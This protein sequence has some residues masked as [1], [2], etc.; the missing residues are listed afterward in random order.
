MSANLEH[1]RALHDSLEYPVPEMLGFLNREGMAQFLE[2]GFPNS[3]VEGFKYTNLASRLKQR[4]F[5]L[6]PTHSTSGVEQLI[7]SNRLPDHCLIVF[8]SGQLALLHA[9][10]LQKLGCDVVAFSSSSSQAT[11]EDFSKTLEFEKTFQQI[12]NTSMSALNQAFFGVSTVE[13][14]LN[15]NSIGNLQIIY[16]DKPGE[17]P[18]LAV[19][20]VNIAVGADSQV[21]VVETFIQSERACD[22][23]CLPVLNIHVQKAARLKLIKSASLGSPGDSTLC[24]HTKAL[25]EEGAQFDSFNF[26][27]GHG[28][29]RHDL[30]VGLDGA[31]AS[32]NVNGVY[33][34]GKNQHVDNQTTLHHK[35]PD[36]RSSQFYK[37]V[38][39]SN[40]RGVF[41]GLVK[42]D[43]DAQRSNASQLNKNLMLGQESQIDTKPELEIAADDVKCSHG[44]TIGQLSELELFYL[45][46]R[47][48]GADQAKQMLARGFI[49]EVID[50]FVDHPEVKS[51]METMVDAFLAE[52]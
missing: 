4:L 41:S 43:K 31:E 48:I 42:V 10:E 18:T 13:L 2:N 16:I 21:Q 6:Q 47:G 7:E 15:S 19:P 23:L 46:S 44:A 38:A 37:G 40:G 11:D 1:Y 28:L 34:A 30:Y 5:S 9:S 22:S 12:E 51:R 52:L 50:E 24:T 17:V 8:V 14:R 45:R 25:C 49:T 33:L 3:K 39:G 26:S 29:V 32:A 27:L 20:R 35:V 36:T